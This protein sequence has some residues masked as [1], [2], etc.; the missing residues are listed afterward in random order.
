MSRISELLNC[1]KIYNFCDYCDNA[2]SRGCSV[3][4]VNCKEEIEKQI[5]SE[6]RADERNAVFDKAYE[7]LGDELVW[8]LHEYGDNV[9]MDIA[10][11]I[12]TVF[13]RMRREQE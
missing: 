9:Y 7:M 13:Q 3:D 4:D 2:T 8:V 1:V 5:V 12:T 6:I 11:S 10:N